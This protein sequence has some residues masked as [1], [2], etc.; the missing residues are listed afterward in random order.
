MKERLTQKH[1]NG[2]GYYLLCS[3]VLRC[4]NKC[5]NC[6]E[7]FKAIDRLGEFED[8]AEQTVD[9]VEVVRCK[10]CKEFS[11]VNSCR[12]VILDFK[13]CK[14]FGNIVRGHDFCSY[15]E[16]RVMLDNEAQLI[17]ANALSNQ[18]TILNQETES[19]NKKSSPK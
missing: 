3:G 8:K 13:F 17:D 5:D 7:F 1:C 9:A 15:G 12:G 19:A 11:N 4:D 14:K 16:R 6:E 10:D 2:N 18:R